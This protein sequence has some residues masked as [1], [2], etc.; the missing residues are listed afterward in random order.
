MFSFQSCDKKTEFYKIFMVYI[1][2]AHK[3]KNLIYIKLSTNM[4]PFI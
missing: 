1:L 3:K 4:G 2:R